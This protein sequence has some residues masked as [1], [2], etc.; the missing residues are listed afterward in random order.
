M[1]PVVC[2]D[3]KKRSI[4]A[5]LP[6]MLCFLLAV[7]LILGYV[8]CYELSL[9]NQERQEQL[10]LLTEKRAELEKEYRQL[11]SEGYLEQQARTLGMYRPKAEDIKILHIRGQMAAETP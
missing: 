1:G 4:G 9:E 8:R 6:W 10:E 11:T 2:R 5:I 3:V 7:V